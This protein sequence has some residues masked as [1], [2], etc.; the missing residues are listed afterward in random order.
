MITNLVLFGASGDLAGRFLLPALAAL[1][2][3][4]RLADDFAV[5]GAA[6]EPW[7]DEAFRRHASERLAEHAADVALEQRDALTK[8]LRYQS[9]DLADAGD[10]AGGVRSV[11]AGP[12]AMYLALPPVL[13]APTL[14]ACSPAQP[15]GRASRQSSASTTPSA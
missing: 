7:D 5:V 3:A 14:T 12:V 8:L 9:P 2:A 11:G 13:F 10:V 6:R 4:G 15:E 1:R